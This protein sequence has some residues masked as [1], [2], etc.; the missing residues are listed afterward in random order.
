MAIKRVKAER[1]GGKKQ[2]LVAG[3]AGFLGYHLCRRLLQDGC[4]VLCVDNLSTGSRGNIELLQKSE[5]GRRFHFVKYDITERMMFSGIDEIYNLACPASPI[6]YQRVPLNTLDASYLGTKNLLEIAKQTGARILQASTSEVYGDPLQH[7]QRET[8][9]GNVN[10]VGLRSCYDEG[11]RVAETLCFVY[12]REYGIKV[13]IARI[14]N[15]YGPFMRSDD[16]RVIS[17]FITQALRGEPLTVYG[18]GL[19]TRSFMFVDDLIDG[20]IRLMASDY[21]EPVNLGNPEEHSVCEMAEKILAY[22]ASRLPGFN[23]LKRSIEYRPLPQDD[24]KQRRPDIALAKE[25]L[26]WEP[27]ISLDDGLAK[28]VE[29]FANTTIIS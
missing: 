23:P 16:G 7:P 6:Q 19:Q 15:T 14:F 9:W 20:L 1:T 26:G 21:T 5:W 28:T 25:A 12:H 3:G 13:H 2:V 22:V 11:K 17:N 24:P 27:K 18:A 8:D 29:Y 10:P 4:L